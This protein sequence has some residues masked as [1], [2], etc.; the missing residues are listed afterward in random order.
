MAPLLESYTLFF[1]GLTHY[2]R[3]SPSVTHAPPAGD[4][5][6]Q[7]RCA[8]EQ[9]AFH[10]KKASR[11]CK[12]ADFLSNDFMDDHCRSSRIKA[13]PNRNMRALVYEPSNRF[14]SRHEL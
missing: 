3:N 7:Q 4:S 1:H 8:D 12:A 6:S 5:P 11:D 13:S 14:V 2:A 9:V 10:S